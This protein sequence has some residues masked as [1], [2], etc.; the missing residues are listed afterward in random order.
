M[1]TKFA[2][3]KRTLLLGAIVAVFASG[4]AP[5]AAQQQAAATSVAATVIAQITADA[6]THTATPA[7][8]LT[9]TPPPTS[10]PRPTWTPQPTKTTGPS[11]TP[12]PSATPQPTRTPVPGT[13]Q[14]PIPLGTS[15]T[16]PNSRYPA[17]MTVTVLEVRRG[18]EGAAVARRL[19]PYLYRAPV[20]KQEYLAVK[21]KLQWLTGNPNK[22]IYTVSIGDFALRYEDDD[23]VLW[24]EGL[25][26]IIDGYVPVENEAWLAYLIREGSQPVLYAQPD[27]DL[28]RSY[29][30]K[31]NPG[32]YFSLVP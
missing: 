21:L 3:T 5:S 16:M 6:P 30:I 8:T 32:L 10:T 2:H 4:C 9:H 22:K 7:A 31:S 27:L 26:K 29:G 15:A 19:E 12:R 24:P 13:F 17:D 14:N 18:K 25:N 11:P 20:D 28:S 23:S 1:F